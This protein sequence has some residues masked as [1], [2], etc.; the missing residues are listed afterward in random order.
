MSDAGIGLEFVSSL[1]VSK[2]HRCVFSVLIHVCSVERRSKLEGCLWSTV[3]VER[4]YLADSAAISINK[5]EMYGNGGYTSSSTSMMFPYDV[6]VPQPYPYPMPVTQ[7]YFQHTT[8]FVDMPV[9][10]T[11]QPVIVP[12]PVAVPFPQPVAVPI[13][14]PCAVPF[15][16]GVPIPQPYAV[17]QPVFIREQVG[18]P[19]PVPVPVAVPVAQQPQYRQVEYITE[20][21]V[22]IKRYRRRRCRRRCRSLTPPPAPL[23]PIIIPIPI[24]APAAAPPAQ[25]AYQITEYV[26]DIYPPAQVFTEQVPVVCESTTGF[27][28]I[29]G[30]CLS[31]V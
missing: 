24:Q 26:Q 5:L 22:Y 7:T 21:P 12:S 19:V 31:V 8:Q 3:S 18:V 10:H 27:S 4:Y 15:P 29:Y 17:P 25:P 1:I 6:P 2:R 23:P 20:E 14:R 16:V 11:I 28:S 30:T 9:P 13:D